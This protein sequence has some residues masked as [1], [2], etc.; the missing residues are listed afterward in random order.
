MKFFEQSDGIFPI[1]ISSSVDGGMYR[2]QNAILKF[3]S[4]RVSAEYEFVLFGYTHRWN[5]QGRASGA[6]DVARPLDRFSGDCGE[7]MDGMLS[8]CSFTESAE[9]VTFG[10]FAIKGRVSRK[11][12]ECG[13]ENF[14]YPGPD[15]PLKIVFPISNWEVNILGGTSRRNRNCG[16]SDLVT[17]VSQFINSGGYKIPEP[18][19]EGVAYDLGDIESG[20]W[21]YG[22]DTFKGAAVNV[23]L[24][25]GFDISYVVRNLIE[26]ESGTF[27]GFYDI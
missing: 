18:V 24:A 5:V 21:V 22:C 9:E 11:P 7:A 10:A 3:S 14:W 13:L 26:R 19:W 23:G 27:E 6:F 16:T 15:S 12:I 25:E 8:L 17:R 4:R 20:F 2:H 1:E